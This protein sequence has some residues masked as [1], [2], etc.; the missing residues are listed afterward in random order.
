[1]GKVTRSSD[2]LSSHPSFLAHGGP[3]TAY[4]VSEFIQAGATVS[5]EDISSDHFLVFVTF[6]KKTNSVSLA[7]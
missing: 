6:K 7:P 2:F 5:I 4:Q 1:V 3:R